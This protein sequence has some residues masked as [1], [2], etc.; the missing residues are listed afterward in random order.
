MTG[1][2]ERRSID[3]S[4]R[5]H[6]RALRRGDARRARRGGAD[7]RHRGAVDVHQRPGPAAVDVGAGAGGARCGPG[8]DADGPSGRTRRLEDLRR[9]DARR[10][11]RSQRPHRRDP[12]RRTGR[13]GGDV[14]QDGRPTRRHRAGA[15]GDAVVDLARPAHAARR[16]ARLGRG[17]SR[18]RGP[19]SRCVPVGYGTPDPGAGVARRRPPAPQPDRQR[20]DRDDAHTPRSHRTRRRG[21]GDVAPARRD[22][23]RVRCC[24]KP[25]NASRS[26]PTRRSSPG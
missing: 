23:T 1:T 18:R 12:L 9:R 7:D 16:A 14:R 19:R 6:R 11:R 20:H 25:T 3:A 26:M 22:P 10:R 21:D 8:G 13:G 24:S 15:C 4:V 5:P 2:V 17:D